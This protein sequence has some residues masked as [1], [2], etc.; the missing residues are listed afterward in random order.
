MIRDTGTPS[1]TGSGYVNLNMGS[2][3]AGVTVASSVTSESGGSAVSLSGAVTDY[4][5]NTGNA[6][7]GN[8]GTAG[9]G[10]AHDNMPPYQAAYCWHRTA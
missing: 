4:S 8:T 6:G 10:N 1:G 9:N 5:G 3:Y 2:S 7:T